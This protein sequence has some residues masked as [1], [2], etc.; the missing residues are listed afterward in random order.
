MSRRIPSISLLTVNGPSTWPSIGLISSELVKSLRKLYPQIKTYRI[1]ESDQA[2][3][4]DDFWIVPVGMVHS[5][6]MKWLKDNF[7][8]PY[9]R[10]RIIFFL[11]GE[12]A[13][14]GYNLYFHQELFRID[15]EWIVSSHVEKNL[16]DHFFPA[17]NRTH[18]LYY[19]VS[20]NFRP[21]KTAAEKRALRKK[22]NLPQQKSYS[23]LLYAGRISVQK[24]IFSLFDVLEKNP[25]FYLIICG[26]VDTLG[27]PHF[28]SD[29]KI[30][31]PILIVEEIAKRKL[32]ARVE[33]R[34]FLSQVELKQMMQACDFQISLSAHYGEDFGYSIA[35]GLAT[36]LKSILSYWGGHI[37]W[38]EFFKASDLTYI[39]LKWRGN[40]GSPE[41]QEELKKP[42]KSKLEF[43]KV[44]EEHFR[45]GISAVISNKT[46]SDRKVNLHVSDELKHYWESFR[47][48]SRLSM[49]VSSDDE[50]FIR[51]VKFYQGE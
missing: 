16:L 1:L 6:L 42:V 10:P 8:T 22:L 33:F 7:P 11:G 46:F 12:G 41:L 2:P 31:L 38:R 51:V 44:Y 37:N 29:T 20:K 17:N 48:G 27:F 47:E 50:M 40:I 5:Q 45:A 19:P 3:T 15:D 4:K 36:G 21:L 34:N 23:L 9:H 13:K 28:D 26:D 14:L 18:V 32:S 39:K 24:N 30:N 25:D 35:Q 49:F 43:H